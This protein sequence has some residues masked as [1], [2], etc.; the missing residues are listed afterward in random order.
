L[1]KNYKKL[2][3]VIVTSVLIGVFLILF[4]AYSA[5]AEVASENNMQTNANNSQRVWV[6]SACYKL[7][8]AV[9][10]K[11]MNGPYRAKYI[12]KS[13]DGRVFVTEKAGNDDSNS[14]QVVFPDDF[15]EEKI[16]QGRKLSLPAGHC[17][18]ENYTWYIY[19]NDVLFDTGT[20]KFSRK[21]VSRKVG[22]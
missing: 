7:N 12:V 19:A 15:R 10:D 11:L 8:L 17:S 21:G 5:V 6:G 20:I 18:H 9:W 1:K 4:S 13:E 22:R 16:F 3:S 2:K 14:A